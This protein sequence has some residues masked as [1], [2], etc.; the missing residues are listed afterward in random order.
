MEHSGDVVLIVGPMFSSKT[1][2]LISKLERF[3]LANKT[4]L[5]IKYT[6]DVRYTNGHEN[7]LIS[8]SKFKFVADKTIYVDCLSSVPSDLIV[9]YDIIAIDEGQFFPDIAEYV[10]EWAKYV[11]TKIYIS[12][13]NGTYKQENFTG[14]ANL[15]P[16]VD[17]IIHLRAICMKCKEVEASFTKKTDTYVEDTNEIDIGGIEKYIAVCR[18]CLN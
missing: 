8:H 5:L 18:D 17:H 13:L 12:A 15:Y 9:T 10:K 6:D 11:N 16:L 2:T 1:T 3:K 4:I 7:S 14:F